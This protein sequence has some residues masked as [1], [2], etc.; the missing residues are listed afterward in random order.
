MSGFGLSPSPSGWGPGST[1]P[2]LI[3][4]PSLDV[5]I[6]VVTYH[7]HFRWVHSL[8]HT[9]PPGRTFF[10]NVRPCLFF[11]STTSVDCV[12]DSLQVQIEEKA[13]FQASTERYCW[14]FFGLCSCF[15]SAHS[16]SVRDL[17]NPQCLL[18]SWLTIINPGSVHS[19]GKLWLMILLKFISDLRFFQR[20]VNSRGMK[21]LW[22][23]C[24][25]HC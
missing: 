1:H 3:P 20:L 14:P 13:N 9:Y 16:A 23:T 6:V 21:N 5:C 4:Q 17:A 11:C 18:V 15:F 2:D 25:L 19:S 24:Q 22:P 12:M 7:N 8:L 10:P